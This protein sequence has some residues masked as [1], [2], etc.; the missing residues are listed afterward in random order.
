MS[1]NSYLLYL[2]AGIELV[3]STLGDEESIL[4][5]EQGE[6]RYGR[7]TFVNYRV[8]FGTFEKK[9]GNTPTNRRVAFVQVNVDLPHRAQFVTESEWRPLP[10]AV[11]K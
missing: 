3:E 5:I 2:R 9:T 7:Q 8:A 11:T 10:S 6:T 1:Q 4:L